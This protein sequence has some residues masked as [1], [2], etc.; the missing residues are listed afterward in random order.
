MLLTVHC[1][2]IHALNGLQDT[3]DASCIALS[4]TLHVAWPRCC[5]LVYCMHQHQL[6]PTRRCGVG[7]A[8]G[9]RRKCWPAA[10]DAA[11]VPGRALLHARVRPAAPP[12]QC[13]RAS[14]FCSGSMPCSLHV[15]QAAREL[16]RAAAWSGCCCVTLACCKCAPGLAC[17]YGLCRSEWHARHPTS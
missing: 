3:E 9:C 16:C 10:A 13:S 8:R 17:P 1:M 6:L 15:C 2:P 7:E 4:N 14:Q 12:G 11:T 5:A